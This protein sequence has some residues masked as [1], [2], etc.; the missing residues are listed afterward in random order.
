MKII[1]VSFLI[2]VLLFQ[3]VTFGNFQEADAHRV[4]NMAECKTVKVKAEILSI[5]IDEWKGKTKNYFDPP[6]LLL[7]DDY[8]EVEIAY[9]MWEPSHKSKGQGGKVDGVIDLSKWSLSK[10]KT[11][12]YGT[13]NSKDSYQFPKHN[14]LL[15]DTCWADVKNLVVTMSVQEVDDGE[16]YKKVWYTEPFTKWTSGTLLENAVT[17]VI[18]KVVK[19]PVGTV[20]TLP[21]SIYDAAHITKNDFLGANSIIYDLE[22]NELKKYYYYDFKTKG[23]SGD[24]TIKLRV[25]ILDDPQKQAGLGLPLDDNYAS[26][27]IPDWIK[28]NADW[29][30]QGLISDKDFASGLGF[31]VKERLIHV[32]NIDFD[33]NGD[34]EI[35][36]DIE[37][38][39][40][41]KNNARW[42]ADG[43]ISDN[44]FKSGIQHMVKE[45][46]ISFKEKRQI[47]TQRTLEMNYDNIKNLYELN[48]WNELTAKWLLEVK[49]T[50]SKLSDD[51]AKSAWNEYS[52]DKTQ[53]LM[54]MASELD[55]IQKE[56]SDDANKLVGVL[57]GIKNIEDAL[58]E[59]AKKLGI[60]QKDLDSSSKNAIKGFDE[61]K[62][63]QNLQGTKDGYKQADKAQKQADSKKT[64]ID[65]AVDDSDN[66][67]K[68]QKNTFILDKNDYPNSGSSFTPDKTMEISKAS[69][70]LV[71][72]PCIPGSTFIVLHFEFK[73]SSN[74]II[75]YPIILDVRQEHNGEFVQNLDL[76]NYDPYLKISPY[77][78]EISDSV[79]H[80]PPGTHSFKIDGFAIADTSTNTAFRYEKSSPLILV[81]IV[82]DCVKKTQNGDSSVGDPSVGDSAVDDSEGYVV[83]DNYSDQSLVGILDKIKDDSKKLSSVIDKGKKIT[84]KLQDSIDD[85]SLP[86]LDYDLTEKELTKLENTGSSSIGLLIE[87]EEYAPNC[88]DKIKINVHIGNDDL[89]NRNIGWP[90]DVTLIENGPRGTITHVV[91][92]WVG[93]GQLTINNPPPGTYSFDVKSAILQDDSKADIF[94]GEYIS[95]STPRTVNVAACN[96]STDKIDSS[97]TSDSQ[98]T[99]DYAKYGEIKVIDR[100]GSYDKEDSYYFFNVG[101]SFEHSNPYFKNNVNSMTVDVDITGPFDN[102]P[103]TKT[104]RTDYNGKI[105]IGWQI[106]NFGTYT[107]KIINF[108]NMGSYCGN[109]DTIT[110]TVP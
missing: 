21:K 57:A 109:G 6:R 40:W 107:F 22:S 79:R 1:L 4:G 85:D 74:K 18:D 27:D 14:I 60:S 23:D 62:K 37:I 13:S 84:S 55:G 30:E 88:K 69:A 78:E 50:E 83:L 91:Q 9:S 38:P 96:D 104:V 54:T 97:V 61:V 94:S 56:V 12:P 71:G 67:I 110:V 32:D 99:D 26:S 25:I 100:W 72:D 87:S 70:A 52:E 58:K 105:R 75:T 48:K 92:T 95:I 51:L 81:V 47:L 53:E 45:N 33:P 108:Q 106:E 8:G 16:S 90:I 29:W 64:Q 82:P 35:S 41:I 28:Q 101:W 103:P 49:N 93:E 11:I 68:L 63:L 66:G 89:V 34:I 24:T 46:V 86:G 15:H 102:G 20:L 59:N 19:G 76:R 10:S 98:C 80:P 2:F 3:V 44:D 36:D 17:T 39:E 43:I 77:S 73:N 42:W 31:M 65:S 7:Y 5:T